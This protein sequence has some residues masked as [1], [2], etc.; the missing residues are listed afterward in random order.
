MLIKGNGGHLSWNDFLISIDKWE[1]VLNNEI[2][3]G[4]VHLSKSDLQAMLNEKRTINRGE[5]LSKSATA[6]FHKDKK[7]AYGGT[8]FFYHVQAA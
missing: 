2:W 7:L 6:E 5:Y 3:R 8:L 1:I 4:T